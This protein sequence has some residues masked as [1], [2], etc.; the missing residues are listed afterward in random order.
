MRA[1]KCIDVSQ[2]KKNAS[3]TPVRTGRFSHVFVLHCDPQCSSLLRYFLTLPFAMIT[4]DPCAVGKKKKN[5]CMIHMLLAI[6]VL[7]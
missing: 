6:S 3:E 7:A 5:P 1:E 4:R 2:G